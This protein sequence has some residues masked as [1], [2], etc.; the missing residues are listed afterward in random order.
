[1]LRSIRAEI[2]SGPGAILVD[3]LR[4]RSSTLSGEHRR[5]GGVEKG[6]GGE[7]GEERGGEEELKQEE[8]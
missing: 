7:D 3:E 6:G 1:M 8:K 4:M 2:P 5:D